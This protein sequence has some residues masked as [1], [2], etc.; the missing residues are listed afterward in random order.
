MATNKGDGN[1]MRT[2]PSPLIRADSLAD[3]Q[4]YFTDHTVDEGPPVAGHDISRQAKSEL[5]LF[6]HVNDLLSRNHRTALGDPGRREYAR[7]RRGQEG[8]RAVG[9]V[10]AFGESRQRTDAAPDEKSCELS[11]FRN[12]KAI[13]CSGKFFSGNSTGEGAACRC[14]CRLR[15]GWVASGSGLA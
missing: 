4:T 3:A 1:V 12:G 13:V 10:F 9:R 11:A 8:V 6:L 15:P 14:G 7:P 2:F 5:G